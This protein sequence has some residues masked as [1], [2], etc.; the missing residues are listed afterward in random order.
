MFGYNNPQGLP[1]APAGYAQQA[2][3]APPVQARDV[4]HFGQALEEQEK[5]LYAL[6]DEVAMLRARIEPMLRPSSPS[7]G[8]GSNQPAPTVSPLTGVVQT[9]N[10]KLSVLIMQVRDLAARF[11]L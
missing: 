2:P 8:E 11:D 7:T 6:N 1:Q 5:L 9:S 4:G 10:V 3:Y